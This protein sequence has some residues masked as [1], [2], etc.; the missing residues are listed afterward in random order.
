L[1]GGDRYEI[2]N[3]NVRAVTQNTCYECVG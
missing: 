3:V 2:Q 1:K